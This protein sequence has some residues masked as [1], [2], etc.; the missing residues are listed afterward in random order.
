[1]IVMAVPLR[2]YQSQRYTLLRQA[3]FVVGVDQRCCGQH[4]VDG[5]G[6][7]SKK[8]LPCLANGGAVLT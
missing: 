3:V 1:M 4:V 7:A 8:V 5:K 2:F 6:K